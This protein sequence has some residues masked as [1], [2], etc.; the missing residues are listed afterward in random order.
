VH[1]YF[2]VNPRIIYDAATIELKELK[3]II[4]AIKDEVIV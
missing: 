3:E 2:G 4:L 1:E